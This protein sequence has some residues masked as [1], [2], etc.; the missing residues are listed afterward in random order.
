[1]H[2]ILN[3]GQI[4]KQ[5]SNIVSL[6]PRRVFQEYSHQMYPYFQYIKQNKTNYKSINFKQE[7]F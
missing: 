6:N 7:E 2:M 5:R 4:Y 1:M 3:K